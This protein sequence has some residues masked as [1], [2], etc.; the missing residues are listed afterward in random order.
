MWQHCR[1]STPTL[2]LPQSHTNMYCHVWF[3][4]QTHATTTTTTQHATDAAQYWSR[5]HTYHLATH[6]GGLGPHEHLVFTFFTRS[7]AS[8]GYL[9]RTAAPPPPPFSVPHAWS[10]HYSRQHFRVW[11]CSEGL[12]PSFFFISLV[13]LTTTPC[14]TVG[15]CTHPNNTCTSFNSPPH[16]C[17][18]LWGCSEGLGPI[19]F[20]IF[21]MHWQQRHASL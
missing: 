4:T 7:R 17:H 14:L 8:L 10:C 2:F 18:R 15:T 6:L 13:L 12:G 9:K 3:S 1:T 19:F 16:P 11:G 5:Q 21:L 20:L